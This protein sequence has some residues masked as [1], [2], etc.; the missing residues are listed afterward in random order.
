MCVPN[1][2]RNMFC[3]DGEIMKVTVRQF[4]RLYRKLQKLKHSTSKNED[5]K[6]A[7]ELEIKQAY[8]DYIDLAGVYLEH[9]QASIEA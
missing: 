6:A 7:K 3:Q 9:T 8:Q 4:K 5:K 1:G 2:M